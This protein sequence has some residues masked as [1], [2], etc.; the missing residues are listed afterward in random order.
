MKHLTFFLLTSTI[1]L[2]SVLAATAQTPTLKTGTT[3]HT[4]TSFGFGLAGTIIST[5]PHAPFSAVLVVHMEQTLNDGTHIQRDNE[6]VVMR[7]GLGRIYRA[8]KMNRPGA[9]Q[10]DPRVLVSIIDPVHKIQ[11]SCTPIKVCNKMGYRLRLTMHRPGGPDLGTHRNLTIE[12]LGTSNISGVEVEG[13]RVTWVIPEGA[14]GN[15][16]PI[17]STEEQWHSEELNV[18]IQVKRADPRAGTRTTTLTELSVGEPDPSYFQIPEGY[19]VHELGPPSPHGLTPLPEES[20][21]T[22]PT[23]T[24][25]PHR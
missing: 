21:T 22:F 15:D 23:G 16:R 3:P 4:V 24:L 6:E 8:R 20:G 7:D 25:P 17:T 14:A 1:A 11:Y 19:S 18:D 12:D 10:P 9:K 2:P 13:K 5:K